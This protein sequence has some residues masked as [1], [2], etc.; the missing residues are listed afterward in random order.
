[1]WWSAHS[2]Q[3]SR[4]RAVL[5]GSR[6]DRRELPEE[7]APRAEAGR[8][9]GET[10]ARRRAVD[11]AGS[12]PRERRGGGGDRARR[13]SR[14]WWGPLGPSDGGDVPV[15]TGARSL[16]TG[17]RGRGG[18]APA[19]TP[20]GWCGCAQRPPR[21]GH[22]DR[23]ASPRGSRRTPGAATFPRKRG[24]H[25]RG[26]TGRADRDRRAPGR[27][28]GRPPGIA[29]LACQGRCRGGGPSPRR[30]RAHR[31]VAGPWWAAPRKRPPDTWRVPLL[32]GRLYTRISEPS[33][34]RAKR[35][36]RPDRQFFDE[37]I[38]DAFSGLLWPTWGGIH[39]VLPTRGDCLRKELSSGKCRRH[40]SPPSRFLEGRGRPVPGTRKARGL[41]LLHGRRLAHADYHGRRMEIVQAL[42][43]GHVA[44][45][46][47]IGYARMRLD[48]LPSMREAIALY[49]ALGFVEIAPY[50]TNPVA[51]ALFMELALRLTLDLPASPAQRARS[52]APF[53]RG[54][55]PRKRCQRGRRGQSVGGIGGE[56][57]RFPRCQLDA[58]PR[59]LGDRGAER[60]AERDRH[61]HDERDDR[62][63]R[64]HADGVAQEPVDGRR[65]RGGADRER[66]V[67]R[68]GARAP[69]H[70]DEVRDGR[71]EDRRGAVE[72]DP[73][74][75]QGG[76]DGRER[77]HDD[78][79]DAGGGRRLRPDDRAE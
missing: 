68:V 75:E 72:R 63:R 47:A 16:G 58:R 53:E 69:V 44:E 2:G 57:R 54:L 42:T 13:D 7:W 41:G 52:S 6:R 3:A 62:E 32:L 67:E 46:R 26:R 30:G 9:G 66:V 10:E 17:S 50:T 59:G 39:Q 23:A 56:R 64:S 34:R 48:T 15:R 76:E 4:H 60:Q 70:G 27:R 61:Q 24:C 35:R 79:H 77:Y 8:P 78:Q 43:P 18:G 38:R 45:A 71:V 51:G 1:G 36:S 5:V 65:G 31:L 28:R 21:P 22:R 49:R 55:R 40:A 19:V 33:G 74:R 11:R 12:P 29:L 14:A 37:R 73:E 20:E 25:P